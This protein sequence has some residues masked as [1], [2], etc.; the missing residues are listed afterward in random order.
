VSETPPNQQ[1]LWRDNGAL[2]WAVVMVVFSITG[3]AAAFG[4]GH[5]LRGLFGLQGSFGD[6]P[7]S[8]RLIY[9]LTIPP[10]YSVLLVVIGTLFGKHRYFKTRALK[11][12]TRLLPGSLRV[13]VLQA[14]GVA[15]AEGKRP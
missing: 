8:Y 12:W 13:R 9:L 5:I 11:M 3:S 15:G 1:P 6:G 14:A 10:C 7:W 4:S 2:H